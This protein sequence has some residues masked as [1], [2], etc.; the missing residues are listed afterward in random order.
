VLRCKKAKC[1]GPIKPT[2]VFFGEAL[3]SAFFEFAKVVDQADLILII[4][5]SLV[6]PPFCL[7]PWAAKTSQNKTVLM[8][9]DYL[10]EW[11]DN[12]W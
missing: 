8:N 12:D 3:P 2:V 9:M 11:E 10:E 6:V 7:I 1:N 4:G 5:T